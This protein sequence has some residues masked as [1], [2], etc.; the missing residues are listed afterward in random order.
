MATVKI[1]KDGYKKPAPRWFR[2]TKKVLS[3]TLNTVITALLIL[4]YTNDSLI[5]LFIKLG[6]SYLMNLF[7][8]I[9]SNGEVYAAP[10]SAPNDNEIKN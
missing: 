5:L 2:L 8:T 10:Y 6:E 1:S 7:D 9:L 4:G 3:L